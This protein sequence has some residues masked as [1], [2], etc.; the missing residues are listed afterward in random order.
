MVVLDGRY[1]DYSG[2]QSYKKVKIFLHFFGYIGNYHYLCIRNQ[3]NK[4][5][6]L[7]L[8]WMRKQEIGDE[9]NWKK[10][11]IH[12]E[13]FIRDTICTNLLHT[14]SF[15]VSS[16]VSKSI[17][18]PV[19]AFLMQN[20]VKVICRENFYGWKLSVE[21]PKKRPITDILPKDIITEGYKSDIS[22]CYFEGFK[23]EWVYP[24][25]DPDDVKQTKFSIGI[26]SDYDFYVAMYMLKHL[27]GDIDLHNEIKNL[28]KEEIV[29]T[30]NVIY[31]AYGY[32]EMTIDDSWGKPTEKR[33]MSG[34]EIMWRT[35]HQLDDYDFRKRYNLD[36]VS[37]DICDDPEKF[38]DEILKYPEVAREFVLEKK[39]YE[40]SF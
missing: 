18:L 29:N 39:M 25:Y 38:A 4:D 24:G 23:D 6:E 21:L 26:Y 13:I 32:N 12:Q 35:Y 15:V 14:H 2:T 8:H 30:I 37:F 34:W 7:L 22:N 31:E 16:H 1:W 17:L 3:T 5:M 40:T 19:Y 20:G 9:M 27:Y 10:A 28:T 11:A 33:I 36:Y